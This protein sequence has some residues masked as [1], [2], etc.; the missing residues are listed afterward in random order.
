[1]NTIINKAALA[2]LF[3]A[4][5]LL[6]GA[7]CGKGSLTGCGQNNAY[8]FL[9]NSNWMPQKQSY[10]VGDTLYLA[11]TIPKI[12]TDQVNT[13][14][15]VDYSNSMGIGGNITFFELDS[16]AH[17]ALDATVKFEVSA[18]T[19]QVSNHPDNPGRLKVFEYAEGSTNYSLLIR[20]IPKQKGIF[21]LFISDLLSAGLQGK[22]CTKAGFSNILT[23]TNKNL[24]LFQFAMQR[25]PAS[26]YETDRIYCFRVQ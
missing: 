20:V 7:S 8:A 4:S 14:I 13:A 12:L 3:I 26:Q 21:A 2:M 9:A 5:Q 11:S 25:P 23:N 10:N 18:S 24:N 6:L 22:N 19:G 15:V 16:M 1:M 17:Q